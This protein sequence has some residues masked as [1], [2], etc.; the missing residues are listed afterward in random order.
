VTIEIKAKDRFK[1]LF[2]EHNV[3]AAAVFK[4]VSLEIK[5]K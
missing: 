2:A 1:A 3:L 5:L 4:R